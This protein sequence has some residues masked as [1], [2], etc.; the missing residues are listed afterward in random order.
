MIHYQTD[1]VFGVSRRIRLWNGLQC[2]LSHVNG[3]RIDVILLHTPQMTYTDLARTL[4]TVWT[5][6]VGISQDQK[7][8]KQCNSRTFSR[9]SRAVS[10]R[11]R[12][13]RAAPHGA[14]SGKSE[15]LKHCRSSKWWSRWWEGSARSIYCMLGVLWSPSCRTS[16]CVLRDTGLNPVTADDTAWLYVDLGRKRES[17]SECLLREG[18]RN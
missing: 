1:C 12:A 17:K 18:M 6:T 15:Q 10:L 7:D 3:T 11:Q 5:S 8:V 16:S 13:L 2:K 4:N 9:A 14:N